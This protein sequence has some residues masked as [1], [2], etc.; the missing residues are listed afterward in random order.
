M[1]NLD[2]YVDYIKRKINK[3]KDISE[4]EIIRYVYLDLG[5]RFSFDLNYIFGNSETKKRIYAKSKNKDDLE[6]DI[7]KLSFK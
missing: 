2:N 4:T 5:N 7:L 3:I 6:V 1:S